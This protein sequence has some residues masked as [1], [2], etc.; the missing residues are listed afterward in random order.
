MTIHSM[1]TL[2]EGQ[3]TGERNKPS[4]GRREC[5]GEHRREREW[6]KLL[7]QMRRRTTGA[8]N[9][10]LHYITLIRF[11]FRW[12]A[13]AGLFVLQI[14][15]EPPI[16]IDNHGRSRPQPASCSAP[17]RGLLPARHRPG[18]TKKPHC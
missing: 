18:A 1:A 9:R 7:G 11:P 16:L 15:P 13:F 5:C 10:E 12:T 17:P 8:G 14:G 3:W 4:T 6:G 2:E